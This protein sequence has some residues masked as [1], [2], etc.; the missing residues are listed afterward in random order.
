MGLETW[1]VSVNKSATSQWQVVSPKLTIAC[2]RSCVFGNVHRGLRLGMKVFRKVT[3]CLKWEVSKNVWTRHN[4]KRGDFQR[5]S[6]IVRTANC[7]T[8]VE[9]KGKIKRERLWCPWRNLVKTAFVGRPKGKFEGK[10][11]M[12]FKKIN[13]D[14]WSGGS[15]HKIT[16]IGGLLY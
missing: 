4:E 7:S 12:N 14:V 3:G 16:S 6:S 10:V 1:I 11:K 2:F 13:F 8:C 5:S 9:N 15:W